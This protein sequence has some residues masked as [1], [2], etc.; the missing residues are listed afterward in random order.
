M[1]SC[2]LGADATCEIAVGLCANGALTSV[3]ILKNG[4]PTEQAQALVEIMRSNDSLITLCGL[5]GKETE[6]DFSGQNLEAGDVVLIANDIRDNRA[7]T[8]LDISANKLTRGKAIYGNGS[9]ASLDS[10]WETDMSGIIAFAAAIAEC[11]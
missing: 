7:M 5:S 1:S 3:N 8:S 11:K 10:H 4:I 2:G 6:L 9:N